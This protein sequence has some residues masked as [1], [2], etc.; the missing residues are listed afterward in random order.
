MSWQISFSKQSLDFMRHHNLEEREVIEKVQ[1]A[2]RKFRGEK[3]NVDVKKLE[4]EWEGFHRI[5]SGKLRIILEF[6][7]ERMR[8]HIEA[9]D[10]RGNIYR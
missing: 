7:F 6:Q 4:G 8:V 2:M 3:V 1:R 9:I 10:W 5:R